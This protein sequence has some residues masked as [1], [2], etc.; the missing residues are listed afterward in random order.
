MEDDRI[1]KCSVG[2]FVALLNQTL[3]YAYP[4]VEIEG[5]VASFKVNQQKYVFFDLKDQSGIVGCFM[6]VFQLRIPIEDGMKVIVRAAPR[7]TMKGKFSLT[8]QSICPSGEGGIKKAFD[9]LKERL[10]KEGLFDAARKRSL[11]EIPQHIGV[12]SSVQAAGYADFIKI[13]DERFG[14]VRVEVANVQVQGEGAADQLIR[15]IEHFNTATDLP[16]VLVI[17]RGG[18]SADDLSTFNDERLV[19]AIASSRVPVLVGVGHEVDTTLA[20]LAADVRAATPSN[21]AQLV[22]PDR[23]E[24]LQR[25]GHQRMRVLTHV[26]T[27]L[28][29]VSR[30]VEALVSRAVGAWSA[31][32]DSL[33]QQ[34][35]TTASTLSAY[36][37]QRVLERGYAVVRGRVTVGAVIEI[38]RHNDIIEAEVRN[39]TTR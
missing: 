34:V 20:D 29:A 19:R 27:K 4:L 17:V 30:E 31:R 8:V 2:E 39:V 3:E 6:T 22:V 21:A 18:G 7:L 35:R 37:P 13:L 9:L 25:V 16:D 10:D 11:P 26:E 38:E 15:A 5:E 1:L 28:R 24:L 12:I 14:G 23:Q 36:D 33:L 32:V